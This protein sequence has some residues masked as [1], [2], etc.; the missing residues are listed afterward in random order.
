MNGYLLV[1]FIYNSYLFTYYFKRKSTNL[2][3]LSLFV[4]LLFQL[5]YNNIL[6]F[7]KPVFLFIC[8]YQ[9][10]LN[11]FVILKLEQVDDDIFNNPQFFISSGLLIY[12]FTISS[13]FLLF[14]YVVN[15]KFKVLIE[16][17]SVLNSF[18]AII[19][20]LFYIKA[21]LCTKKMIS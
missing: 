8:L 2:L 15:P 7:N 21:F 10:I 1:I 9:I 6:H 17:F 13:C 3:I 4:I 16:Y 14:D 18:I 12:T 11:L 5:F 20:N 19:I